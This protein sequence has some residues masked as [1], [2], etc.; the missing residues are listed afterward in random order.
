M[1]YNSYKLYNNINEPNEN[2]KSSQFLLYKT[3]EFFSKSKNIN[4]TFQKIYD[5]SKNNKKLIWGYL[6]VDKK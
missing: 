1:K 3:I 5:L 2:S 6:L 4:K